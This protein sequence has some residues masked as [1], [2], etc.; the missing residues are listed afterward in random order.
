[1]RFAGFELDRVRGELRR[2][3]G[4][5]L[6]LRPK[7]FTMLELFAANAGRILSKEELMDAVWPNVHV[8]EDSLFKC[9]REIRTALGDDERQL[10][11]LMSGRGYLFDAEVSHSP[12]TPVPAPADFQAEPDQSG[13]ISAPAEA[14]APARRFGRRTV[15]ALAAA[16]AGVVLTGLAIVTVAAPDIFAGRG[17]VR[18]AVMPIAADSDLAAIAADVTTRLSDGLAKIANVRVVA[19]QVSA[20]D[21]GAMRPDFIVSGELGKRE[22]SWEVQARMIR[23]KTG[24]IVWNT[25]V[26]VATDDSDLKLQ[27]S[28]LA[29]S[30]G[31]PLAQ[32][33][34]VL[35]NSDAKPN[36]HPTSAGSAAVAI[37]QALA[38]IAKT[39]RERFAAS[40]TMLEK[41]IADNPDNVDLAVALAGLQ[42]RGV[43]MVW[44]TPDQSAAVE[45]QARAVLEQGLKRKPTYL[46]VLEAY[47]RFLNATNE[48]VDSLVACA[49]V[50][51][52]DPWNGIAL[53]NIGLGQ[54]QLGRFDDA[55]ATFKEADRFDTPPASRW[56]WKLGAGLTYVLMGN[57]EDAIPWLQR[58]IAITPA[59]GRSHMM[60]SACYQ[61]LGRPAEART[62]M[63]TAMRL[64]PGSN[65]G[66]VVL[67]PKNESAAYQAA[68]VWINDALVASG[69][70]ER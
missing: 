17:P 15:M 45:S 7:T 36:D 38:S 57:C 52:F 60:L 32:R 51:S 59:T 29:A 18:L 14:A 5:I 65:L 35:I 50:L 43:Q 21:A 26:S 58:S 4:E 24:D 25:P 48:F 10:I 1:M 13:D 42:L 68:I 11:K 37:D 3:D 63:E 49:R 30:I 41:A 6:K 70:P 34:N 16:S 9:I 53:F 40:Q 28:R 23:T 19:P 12:A 31:Q 56:T 8:A 47:C 64:R 2:A 27:Q 61:R 22:G 55:L 44:F 67:P 62:A 66:N 69:L 33:I 46:P 20:Q 39:T 54:M